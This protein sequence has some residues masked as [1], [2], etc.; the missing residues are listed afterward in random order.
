MEP[1][2][3]KSPRASGEYT[4]TRKPLVALI[5]VLAGLC[6]GQFNLRSQTYPT[7]GF[8]ASDSIYIGIKHRESVLLFYQMRRESLAW[9]KNGDIRDSL[10]LFIRNARYSGLNPNG[11]HL[12]E[13]ESATHVSSLQRTDILLTDAFFSLRNDLARGRLTRLDTK[14]DSMA[15]T[16]LMNVLSNGGLEKAVHQMEPHT[17]GYKLLKEGLKQILDTLK[18]EEKVPL[19][20]GITLDSIRSHRLVKSIEINLERWRW[21]RSEWGSRYIL[22]NIPSFMATVISDDSVILRSKVIVG[23]PATRTPELSSEIQCIITYPYWHVPRKIATEEFLPFIKKDIS[24]LRKN[25]LDVLDRK[26]RILNP[27]SVD[28]KSLSKESFPVQLRQREGPE[29]ALGVLK[30]VFDN[31][32]GVFLHDTNTPRLFQFAVRTFSHGCIRMERAVDFAHY[33]MTGTPETKSPTLSRYLLQRVRHTV[34]VPRPINIRVRYFTAEYSED[35][36]HISKD[37]YQKDKYL[38]KQLYGPTAR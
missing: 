32:Y 23:K 26:G 35:G 2:V 3:L 4:S 16:I 27:D 13:I 6:I 31:P 12:R 29:N 37:V 28:W 10:L 33:L 30:F 20:Q 9:A 24:F 36:L 8:A 17:T 25:N 38:L 11:Y 21:E 22:I 7:V 15:V 14:P 5:A 18:W 1:H 34:E 19:M